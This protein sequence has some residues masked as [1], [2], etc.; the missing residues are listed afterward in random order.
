MS[1]AKKDRGVRFTMHLYGKRK[2]CNGKDD[3]DRC[4]ANKPCAL[5]VKN[6]QTKETVLSVTRMGG[7]VFI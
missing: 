1:E 3:E 6:H 4:Y 5:L 7:G 2:N